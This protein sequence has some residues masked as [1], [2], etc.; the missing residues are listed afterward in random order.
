MADDEDVYQ[1]ERIIW[2][3][4]TKAAPT[5]CVRWEGYDHRGDT[6]EPRARVAG[7]D[8][9]A[10]FEELDQSLL[11][12]VF[13]F[14]DS[15]YRIL[16]SNTIAERDPVNEKTV[17]IDGVREENQARALLEYLAD[18]AGIELEQT[19]DGVCLDT[20]GDLDKIS[21]V[22]AGHTVRPSNMMGSLRIKCGAASYNDMS[23]I[24]ALR[25]YLYCPPAAK[26]T[27]NFSGYRLEAEV[28]TVVFNGLTG[29]PRF[30]KMPMPT[31]LDP[32]AKEERYEVPERAN[33]VAHF[34][35]E[36][37]QRYSA[38]AIPHPLRAAGWHLLPKGTHWLP[39]AV[40]IPG[41]RKHRPAF[42]IEA[43]RAEQEEKRAAREE[44]R[45]TERAKWRGREERASAGRKSGAREKA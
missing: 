15:L 26:I 42:E 9:L 43:E 20:N 6:W 27:Y 13:Y 8:A 3:G 34:K 31:K 35:G 38:C 10:T 17:V 29:A 11:Q 37:A 2:G 39:V 7:T 14:R 23:G 5:R 30:P 19:D 22:V 41:P 32:N 4:G 40:A 18:E 16:S 44:K 28:T 24:S 12:G 33:I 45:A 21:T 36:L 1:V 25:V